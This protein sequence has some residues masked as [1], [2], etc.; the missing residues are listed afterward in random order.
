MTIP[1]SQIVSV[2]PSVITGGGTGLDM[3]AVMLT[4]SDRMP[5]GTL[6]A[7]PDSD[8]IG[9]YF[10]AL[11][12][13]DTLGTQYFLG[14]ENSNIKPGRLMFYAYNTSAVGAW[15]RGSSP[16]GGT[17]LADIVSISGTLGLTIDGT[18]IAP[19]SVDLSGSASYSAAAGKIE[20][21]L[22]LTAGQVEWDSLALAF[23]ISSLTTGASSTITAATGTAA[24]A[25]GFAAASNPTLSQG[26]DAGVPATT[27]DAIKV[28]SQNWVSFMTTFDPDGGTGNDEKFAFAVWTNGQNK[29]FLYAA[30][31][32][33]A[34]AKNVTAPNTL[35]QRIAAG[36][37]NG[38]A[39]M[40]APT[41]GALE[42]AFLCGAIASIDFNE[43]EGRSTLAF[44]RGSGITPDVTDAVSPPILIQNG[45]NF[46]GDYAT[47]NDDFK[48]FY[49]GQ[50]S[51]EFKW[52]DSYVNQIWLNNGIQLALMSYVTQAKSLPY[53]RVGYDQVAAAC[54]DPINKA[55]NFGAIRAGVPMSEAQRSLVAVSAGADISTTLYAQGWYLQVKDADAQ[56]RAL[57]RSPPVTLWYMD[58]QSIQQINVASVEVM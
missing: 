19:A 16:P 31:D 46:Y 9:A 21:A 35:A 24:A 50:V 58:G 42:A 49:P 43:T 55:V 12:T 25:L 13:E 20:T 40:Y 52:I 47:A 4:N 23:K 29:R 11:S 6:L 57:R 15:I 53:N 34:T 8:S 17:T 28:L 41:L 39:S 7:F 2:T 33:D 45:Y 10:G 26:Q 37:Y 5:T 14:F 48:F 27:M 30:W 18:T 44:K 51:G 36:D 56:T 54:R 32:T 22:G 38:I 3:I 1:A